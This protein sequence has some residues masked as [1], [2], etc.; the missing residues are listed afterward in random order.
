MGRIN[1]RKGMAMGFRDTLNKNQPIV[2][3]AAMA[4]IVVAGYFI[5]SQTIGTAQGP[6]TKAFYTIDDGKTWFRDDINKV[7][8]FDVDGKA[9]VEA[10]V[11]S[12]SGKQFAM[13]LQKCSDEG[14]K[15]IESLHEQERRS[16]QPG[17]QTKEIMAVKYDPKYQV[18]KL[19]GDQLWIPTS[20]ISTLKN[21]GKCPDGSELTSVR[22]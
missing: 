4:L 3:G 6:L 19:P 10:I 21:F 16:G 9:A 2:L 11:A 13:Y 7:A 14:T 18:C 15:L 12:C 8:P 1:G 22:P 5:Y 17:S 20:A